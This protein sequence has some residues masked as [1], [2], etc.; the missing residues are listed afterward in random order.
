[1]MSLPSYVPEATGSSHSFWTL[2]M[3]YGR[4]SLSTS[5]R[6]T[7]TSGAQPEPFLKSVPF[8]GSA[9][10]ASG[11]F[12]KSFIDARLGRGVKV[13]FLFVLCLLREEMEALMNLE[14]TEIVEKLNKFPID[15]IADWR[16]KPAF[17]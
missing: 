11:R 3:R 2:K 9:I 12:G 5:L 13:R 4:P 14:H 15:E 6:L 7:F 1:M 16:R 10:W 17:S 8:Y